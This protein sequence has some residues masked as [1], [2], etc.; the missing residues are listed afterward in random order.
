MKLRIWQICLTVL[1]LFIFHVASLAQVDKEINVASNINKNVI[2]LTL[3]DKVNS[4]YVEAG[5]LI[6]AVVERVN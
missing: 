6:S 5:P 3:D 4:N 1:F 2:S